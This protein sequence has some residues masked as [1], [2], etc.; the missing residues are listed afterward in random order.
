MDTAKGEDIHTVDICQG[1]E[2]SAMI[3]V[4]NFIATC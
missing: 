1:A 3:N 4:S 2:I